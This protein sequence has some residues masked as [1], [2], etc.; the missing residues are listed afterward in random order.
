MVVPRAYFRLCP[1][2]P[3]AP[4]QIHCKHYYCK[5]NNLEDNEPEHNNIEWS[6]LCLSASLPSAS[7]FADATTG[8]S[9]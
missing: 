7:W 4:P 3:E 6:N 1:F 5:E 2:I 9:E 8:T